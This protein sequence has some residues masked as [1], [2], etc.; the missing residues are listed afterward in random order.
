MWLCDLEE[1]YFETRYHITD[2]YIQFVVYLKKTFQ[3][4]L[5]RFILDI[6]LNFSSSIFKS[7]QIFFSACKGSCLA[8]KLLEWNGDAILFIKC[9]AM[10][11]YKILKM[12]PNK[13]IIPDW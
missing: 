12:G 7:V 8:S 10:L 3:N 9:S 5:S 4:L 2:I 1:S 13:L 6:F 11:H